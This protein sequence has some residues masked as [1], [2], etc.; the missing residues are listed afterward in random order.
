VG[1]GLL[2]SRH[3]IPQ[4]AA[5]L[6]PIDPQLTEIENGVKQLLQGNVQGISVIATASSAILGL[7]LNY[8]RNGTNKLTTQFNNLAASKTAIETELKGQVTQVTETFT[9]ELNTTRQTLIDVRSQYQVLKNS[10]D[11]VIEQMKQQYETIRL[12]NIELNKE[13]AQIQLV[14]PA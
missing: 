2:Y 8:F 11:Q 10:T 9:K 7:A 5:L 13:L 6:T 1:A 3:Y 14:V 4:V 12:E